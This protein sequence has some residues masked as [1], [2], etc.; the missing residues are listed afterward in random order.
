M[1]ALGARYWLRLAPLLLVGWLLAGCA[2][3][4]FDWAGLI[5]KYTYDQ[6]VIDLGPP[7]KYARL[8]DGALVVE[9]LTQRGYTYVSSP[10]PYGYYPW[11]S[12]PAYPAYMNTYSSPDYFL[13]LVFGP[14]GKLVAWKKFAK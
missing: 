1:K 7:D 3:P 9:W 13:R 4:Q 10:Y 6:A 2:T 12:G 8:S 14:D 11:W 5:G